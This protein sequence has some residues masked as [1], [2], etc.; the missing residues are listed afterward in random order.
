MLSSVLLPCLTFCGA[1]T[2]T[3]ALSKLAQLR[4]P[5]RAKLPYPPGPTPLPFL[6]NVL[7]IDRAQPWVSYTEMQKK[8]GDIIYTKLL[9]SDY[10]IVNTY[11]AAKALLEQRSSVYSDRPVFP[12]NKLFGI[13]F[14]T[15]LQ[16][17]G[18]TWRL[19]RKL[20]HHSLRGETAIRYQ[21]LY[22]EKAHGLLAN[23]LDA[24]E[25]FEGHFRGFVA[26]IVMAQTYGYETQPRNDPL[27]GAV[28]MLIRLLAVALS[29]ER[30]AIFKAFPALEKLPSWFPG[31]GFKR[32][33]VLARGLAKQVNDVPFEFVKRSLAENTA[34]PSMVSDLLSSFDESEDNNAQERA[35]KATA[36]TVFIAGSETSSSTLHVFALAMLRY[37]EVQKRAQAEIDSVVGR[38]RLPTFEDRE[39]LPYVECI[40]RE[41]LRWHPVVPLGIPHATSADDVY[42]GYYIPKGATVMMNVWAM[43]RDDRRYANPEIFDPSRHLAPTPDG[44]DKLALKPESVTN[45]PIFGMGRRICPGRYMSDALMWAAIVSI[46][47]AFRIEKATDRS[48]REIEVEEKF[49]PGLAM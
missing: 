19:H 24:P 43:T 17:Y 34:R 49:T 20:F 15:V 37:P 25:G 22:L 6:G 36:A 44:S 45:D 21:N 33:A 13:D 3:F 29:P 31:A 39:T 16:P 42:G 4:R 1:F 8:Y 12:A 23:L 48:G 5:T 2:L 46:L 10:I 35:M 47:A 38:D 26:S 7:D 32:D 27:V 11:D 28:D 18:D 9:G 41:L 30:M 14:N 40:W